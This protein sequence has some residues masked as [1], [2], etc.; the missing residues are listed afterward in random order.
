M[1][2]LYSASVECK[3]FLFI[4]FG[5]MVTCAYGQS[6]GNVALYKPAFQQYLFTTKVNASR[7]YASNALDG[8][9][10]DL[11]ALG[12]QCTIS[13]NNKSTATWWVDLTRL[14]NIDRIKI[15]HR[16]DNLVWDSSNGYTSRFLG[17][18]VYVSNTTS[19]SDGTLCFKDDSF[20]IS[21]IPEVFN[22]TC[23]IYGQ[24][25][26]FYNERLPGVAYP[27]DYSTFAFA[28]ICEFEVYECD[29]GYF[30]DNCTE[31]CGH[32]IDGTLCSSVDGTCT[33]GCSAGYTGNLCNRECARGSYGLNCNET[34]G[35][36]SDLL[37]CS[38]VNGTC[39][40][41]CK[42]GFEGERCQ[43]ECASGNYGLK[44][45]ETC[46]HC[47][48]L[49]YCSHVNGKCLTGCMPGYEGQL[50]SRACKFGYYGIDCLQECSS[51]CK[52]SRD[53]NH[54]T[55]VC[56]GGCR[57]GWQGGDCFDVSKVV[58]D[59]KDWKSEFY[60][61]VGAVCISLI[62]NGVLIAYIIVKWIKL[63]RPRLLTNQVQK[64][65]NSEHTN[66][67]FYEDLCE[68]NKAQLYE[69]Y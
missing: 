28:D 27:K 17:F 3:Y 59:K 66:D 34:C 23:N 7:F 49:L 52:T 65:R 8:L 12:G 25:V 51:F 26:I 53:C 29:I 39:L 9:I 24:Y 62:L 46:G 31:E 45:N 60:G 2:L 30:G 14:A 21:T 54:L 13:A 6:S 38:K 64:P 5:G 41:G 68:T 61:I 44:C 18:S 56:K 15:Y 43:K 48:D 11:S 55:G 50:C 22:T 36:C 33:S 19:I 47:F 67:T 42:P 35:H 57:D 32:C 20:N 1:I 63:S 10:S 37:Y 40:T 69:T 58:G 4:C 16:T